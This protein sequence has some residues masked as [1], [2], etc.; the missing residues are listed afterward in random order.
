MLLDEGHDVVGLDADFFAHCTVGDPPP[1]VPRIQRDVRDVEVRDLEGFHAVI[2]LAALSN[3]PLGNLDPE[4]TH[5]VNHRASVRLARLA[6]EAGVPRFV[7]SS[8]CS[9]YGASSD[10]LLDEGADLRPVTPYGQSKVWT[11]RDVALLAD[12]AFTPVFLRNATAYGASPR[13]RL[14]LVINDF[15]ARAVVSG[16]V[17]IM[18]DGTP[19]R[20][21]VH[22]EDICRA[23]LAAL[24][25][26]REAVHN[27]AFNVGRSRENYRVSELAEIV[28]AAI[29]GTTIEY[30]ADGGPDKRCYRVSCE[31]IAAA[32]PG[33][34][35]RWD[36]RTG[37]EQLYEFYRD[38]GLTEEHLEGPRYFRLRTLKGLLESGRLAP[39]LRWQGPAG[40]RPE[41]DEPMRC[42]V[43]S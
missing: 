26:P 11:E 37:V 18:S 31:K 38:A 7:F 12:D 5:A 15:V 19:W 39:D 21:L 41:Q 13:L 20:P 14:D 33:F 4:L 43:V 8:S 1:G 32:L 17:F 40:G 28:R 16:R 35:P 34:Q 22:V 29:P 9:S 6:K 3:D 2:H 25:A 30:A 27:Q 42:E 23:F 10:G 36:V 24:D